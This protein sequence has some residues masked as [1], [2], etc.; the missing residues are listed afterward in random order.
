M[1]HPR[2]RRRNSHI[3][4]I[5]A[6][7]LIDSVGH[8]RLTSLPYEGSG[9]NMEKSG[10]R[11]IV[12]LV[13]M[14]MVMAVPEG[15]FAFS[16]GKTGSSSTGCGGCHGSTSTVTP[17][18]TT[19]IPSSGYTAGTVYS[20]TIGGSGG[21][22]GTKGGFNLDASSG[23]FSNP[24]TN[25]QIVV[26]EVTHSNSNSRT[27]TVDWTAPSTGSGDVT[28]FLALNFVNGNGGTSGDSWGTDSW[29][30]SEAASTTINWS[31][32]QP[33]S[34]RGSV[35]SNSIL[36]L[37]TGS[38]TLVLD[39]GTTVTFASGAGGGYPVYSEGDVASVAGDCSILRN[40]SLHCSGDNSYGQLGLGSISA[41][42]GYV[43]FGAR[44]A[45]AVTD[46]NNHNCAILDDGSVQCWGRNNLGQLGDASN[47]NRISPASVNL[48]T[49]RT[50]VSISAG[51]DFTCALLD[52]GDISCWGDN[53]Y[54][55]LA[56]GTTTSSNAPIVVNHSAGNRPVSIASS[57][58]S[59]CAIMENGSVRCWGKSYTVQ[60]SGGT[61]TNGSVEIAIP[62]GRTAVEIDGTAWHTCVILD[63][64]SMNCW[65]VNT[66]GQWGDGSCSSVSAGSGCTGTDSNTPV[67]TQLSGS[68]IAIAAGTD[69]TCALL[70]NYDLQCWGS[71]SGEFDGTS[72]DLLLPHTM[73]FTHGS[74]IA[75]S[76]QDFDGDGIWN[77]LDTH[78]SGDDDGDGVPSPADP[79]PNNPARWLSCP[80]GQWGRLSC[81]DSPSGH[82][83]SQGEL[84][85]TECSIG[86][87]QPDSGQSLCHQASAGNIVTT[88]SA[89]NQTPCTPGSYQPQIGQTACIQASSGN[90]SNTF[91]GDAADSGTGTILSP[92]SALYSGSILTSGDSADL[93]SI[94]VPRDHGV[95][96]SL[97]SSSGSDFNLLFTD[98][99][100]NIISNSSSNSGN[101]AENATTNNTNF[102]YG[103]LLIWVNQ[104]AVPNTGD[105]ELRLWLFSTVSG[106]LVGNSTF[107]IS[108]ELGI[109][110]YA[111][112]PG[113]YQPDP[114]MPDCN[115]ASSG[116]FVSGS[117]A[118]SQQQCSP[119]TYQPSIGQTSCLNATPGYYVSGYASSSQ[120]PASSGHYVNT[121][122]ATDDIPCGVGTFQPN[123]GQ[124][125]CNDSDPG[126]Y[127]A[128]T[129]QSSQ[130]PCS[131]GTYQ[132]NSG[133]TSCNN[134]DPG[135]FVSGSAATN[136]T[137]CSPGTYQPNSG[138]NSCLYASIGHFVSTSGATTQS[139]CG[140][141]TYQPTTGQTS[142][143]NA[144]PGH[145]VNSTGS[146]TQDPCSPG[147][148]Q[149]LPGQN[150]CILANP[151]HYVE[152]SGATEQTPCLAGTYNPDAGSS[153]QS[154][155]ISADAGNYVQ[156]NGSASQ[157]PCFPGS[158]QDQ[159]GQSSCILAS[160]GNYSAGYGSINQVQCQVGTFQNQTGMGWCFGATPGYYVEATGSSS[161]TACLEGTYNPSYG[162]NS[163]EDCLD[164]ESG[165]FVPTPGSSSQTECLAGTF[166][167]NSGQSACINADP[168]HHVPGSGASEQLECGLGQ[169]QDSNGSDTCLEATPGNYVDSTGSVSQTQCPPTTYNSATGSDSRD[170]CIDVDPGYYSS[171]W[172]TP[173]QIECP[174]GT[175]QPNSAQSLCLDAD[176]GHFVSTTASISQTPCPSG[177]YNPFEASGSATDCMPA[178]PGYFVDK[179]ASSSQ[180]ACSPGTYQ[181]LSGQLSCADADPGYFV[182]EEGQSEQTAAPLDTYVS[183]SAST[184]FEN[185]PENHITIQ[186]GASSS[187]DCYLDTDGD[188]IQDISDTDDDGDGVDDVSD[189]CPLGLM[190]WSSSVESDFDADGCRDIDE[191]PDDDNDGFPD[192]NDALPLN[193]GEWSDNDLD[194]IGDN[195]DTDDDNDDLLDSDEEAIG[196]DPK[197]ADTDDDGFKDGVD[198]FPKDPAEWADSDGDGHGDNGDAFP[199][200]PAKHLEEDFIAKYGLV[201][202]LV[203]VML[204][205]GLGGWMV[206][207]RKGETEITPSS[208]QTHSVIIPQ[209]EGDEEIPTQEPSIEP[210]PQLEQEMDTSQFLEELESDLQRPNPPPDAKLNE[211]GQLVWIDDSGTVYAQNPDGSILTFDVSTGAWTPHE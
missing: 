3:D 127:V 180:V 107:P 19:G 87:Y 152:I 5:T 136:Q 190:D 173:E 211:Q 157:T 70:A 109:S 130:T 196:T 105:Y 86:T 141:G 48:G 37:S 131:P 170:D 155:C 82:Y 149:S 174:L 88:T 121:S 7:L 142:C 40:T 35:F 1:M 63:N 134:A 116:H 209:Q 192:D 128:N 160:L 113:T 150:K 23:T 179:Q 12:I 138:Q 168:G 77:S 132:P 2:T 100:L 33:G 197:D 202:G 39:N 164:A 187:D 102:T 204:V 167:P 67:H 104:G 172:G 91:F 139:P 110:Q 153:S 147:Y 151:G 129:G 72:D 133:Q 73:N 183:G 79:Y 28:F 201:I 17:T 208:E 4:E 20:L 122:G 191:D 10:Q 75:F 54:G 65:G 18:L 26:G 36:Y 207:R 95:S 56:D 58:K 193:Q 200:D 44:I 41:T 184:S 115:S 106:N 210:A 145:Y 140:L 55:I 16:G 59:V 51:I 176:S 111:C 45:V 203:V 205:V 148:Y 57:G 206:M 169:Y 85:Y 188:R 92:R 81:S 29:T 47:T 74:A 80:G 96:V 194:G 31:L 6:H 78:M 175:Y 53:S 154:A 118:V 15:A 166:Q 32:N 71:Q 135:Y 30:V 69:S 137:M 165:H 119:G 185:C 34:D 108:V 120:T 198:A 161:Q 103:N 146:S 177:T 14:V 117:G 68:A 163:S 62:T 27:W 52:N 94:D 99:S 22:S 25:A 64:A 199:N 144:S 195:S 101:L 76:E 156:D 97:N 90:Y 83:S 43:N 112:S 189:M 186:Q 13:L 158:W 159:T 66:H 124:T 114:G 8:V 46:G 24:G 162:S 9:E 171:D 89:V 84:Y 123:S 126:H 61:V 93:Y 143:V 11:G 50:A 38:P 49:N 21:V 125:S 98:L 42:S 181:E 182:P 60:S 178:D